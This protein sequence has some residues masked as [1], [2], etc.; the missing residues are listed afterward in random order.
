L[1]KY[2]ADCVINAVDE[3]R[4]IRTYTCLNYNKHIHMYTS[5]HTNTHLEEHIL[6]HHVGECLLLLLTI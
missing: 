4:H 1:S 5:T 2:Y 6:K 3:T